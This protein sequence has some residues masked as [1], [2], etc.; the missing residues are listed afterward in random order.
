MDCALLSLRINGEN[1][2]VVCFKLAIDRLLISGK[3]GAGIDDGK[4]GKNLEDLKDLKN[5]KFR[6]FLPVHPT[7]PGSR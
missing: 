6:S 2:P 1:G 4:H 7:R 5:L 3:L